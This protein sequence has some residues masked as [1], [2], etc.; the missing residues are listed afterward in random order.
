MAPYQNSDLS[1]STLPPLPEG[2]LLDIMDEYGEALS[3][4]NDARW[5]EA[6]VSDLDAVDL[7]DEDEEEEDEE[8]GEG[9]ALTVCTGQLLP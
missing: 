3:P 8:D 2:Q 4:V 5:W 9:G 6:A 7:D 1:P